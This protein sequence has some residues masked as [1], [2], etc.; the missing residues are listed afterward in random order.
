MRGLTPTW[1]I[2]CN[3]N[4]PIRVEYGWR[5]ENLQYVVKTLYGE[6]ADMTPMD[7]SLRLLTESRPNRGSKFFLTVRLPVVVGTPTD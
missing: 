3:G 4:T 1:A 6:S 2:W 7:R 5:A